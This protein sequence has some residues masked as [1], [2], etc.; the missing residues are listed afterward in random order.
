MKYL[1][2]LKCMGFNR[3]RFFFD[4]SSWSAKGRMLLYIGLL[5]LLGR[6][7]YQYTQKPA[8]K[9]DLPVKVTVSKAE[10][11]DMPIT[12]A[13]V[14]SVVP[15]ESV[16]IKSR[17]DSQII[18]V[19]FK[20]GD[21]VEEGAV[22]FELDSRAI[23]AQLEQQKSNL[24]RDE[25][26]LSRAKRQLERDEKL[27][28]SG[29]SSIEKYDNSKNAVDAASASV[30]STK[31]QVQNLETQLDY[32]TIRAPISGRVGTISLTL[33]NTVKANDTQALVTINKIK[34]IKVQIPVPQRYVSQLQQALAKGDVKVI[35]KDTSEQILGEG[36]ITSKENA[37]DETTRNLSFRATFVN[38]HEK[39]WPGMF[40][41]VQ[42]ILSIESQALVVP[43]EAIQPGQKQ[44][45]L[46]KIVGDKAKK[47]PITLKNTEGEFTIIDGEVKP[48]EQVVI[49]GHLRLK[50]GSTVDI[51]TESK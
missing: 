50:D 7:G 3:L 30:L 8:A 19:N 45:Y 47:I 23:R 13:L 28:T 46:Y 10:L 44:S 42:I 29:F 5:L 18:K 27:K 4:A 41:N 21:S 43:N 33:G 12:I 14:G 17:I 16:A 15:Y 25:A 51:T 6:C 1:S 48:Q 39:L 36:L 38:D 31:A 24:S 2:L 22:L 40:V 32:S 49:D 11:K 26:E 9:I 37:L 35:A 34:P 20:D